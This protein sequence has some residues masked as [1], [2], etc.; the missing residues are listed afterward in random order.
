LDLEIEAQIDDFN[1]KLEERLSDVNFTTDGS[2][3]CDGLFLDDKEGENAG[4]MK[5]ITPTEEECG[6]MSLED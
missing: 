3:E 1:T 2:D 5:G 6:D 4:V